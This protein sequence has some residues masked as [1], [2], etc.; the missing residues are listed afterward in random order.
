MRQ[1]VASIEKVLSIHEPLARELSDRATPGLRQTHAVAADANDPRS[2]PR[3]ARPLP[4]K[5]LT[6][7][8]NYPKFRQQSLVLQQ[9]LGVYVGL[10]AT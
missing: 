4:R 7:C 1:V 8:A 3:R 2:W 9:V 6:C 10:A 5:F